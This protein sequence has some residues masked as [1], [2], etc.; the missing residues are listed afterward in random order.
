MS[1]CTEKESRQNYLKCFR[2][3]FTKNSRE[4]S[5]SYV[6]YSCNQAPES[7]KN[8]LTT[9]NQQIESLDFDGFMQKMSGDALF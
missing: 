5:N 8:Q 7:G 3:L 1:I 6:L 9:P 4:S 2:T